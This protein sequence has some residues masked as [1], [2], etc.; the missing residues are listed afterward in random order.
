M[1]SNDVLTALSEAEAAEA[2]R[3]AAGETCNQS[4][5]LAGRGATGS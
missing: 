2:A 5:C 4:F 1:L 3:L